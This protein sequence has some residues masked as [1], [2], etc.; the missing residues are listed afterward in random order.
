M[1]ILSF[2]Y[3]KYFRSDL[4]SEVRHGPS[5]PDYTIAY[6][7]RISSVR[8]TLVFLIVPLYYLFTTHHNKKE[9]PQAWASSASKTF[10]P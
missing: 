2:D 5:T 7:S 3:I 1:T 8:H 4:K 6:V 9:R 10:T